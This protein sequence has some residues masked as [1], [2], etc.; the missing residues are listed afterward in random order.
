M[1]IR[2][3]EKQD[4]RLRHLQLITDRALPQE[5][6]PDGEEDDGTKANAKRSRRETI[7][8]VLFHDYCWQ[9]HQF[10]THHASPA[11]P[12]WESEYR[13]EYPGKPTNQLAKPQVQ[14]YNMHSKT[15]MYN[16]NFLFA[17]IM[18]SLQL[19]LG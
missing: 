6:E 10:I 7:K 13:V 2:R 8:G 18:Y 15:A 16:D 1:L 14:L 17:G 3:Q 11:C 12:P 19:L 4:G 9:T 5:V